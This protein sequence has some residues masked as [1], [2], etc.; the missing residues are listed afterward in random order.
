MQKKVLI[1]GGGVSGLIAA[2][3][4]QRRGVDYTL[5]EQSNQLGGRIAT[6][7]KN[8]YLFDHGFQVL[9][10]AYPEAQAYLDY[11]A[12]DLKSFKPGARIFRQ[13]H[14]STISDPFRDLSALFETLFSPIATLNDK[15]LILKLRNESKKLSI[16]SLFKH[17]QLSTA[18][19]LSEYG[20][21]DSIIEQ[22]FQP[23]FAG[24][25]LE[26]G[27]STSADAF[28]FIYK[29]FT[30]GDAAVPAKGIGAIIRQLEERVNPENILTSTHISNID[31]T[32]LHL[33]NGDVLQGTDVI[34][35]TGAY[36]IGKNLDAKNPDIKNWNGTDCI[37][38]NAPTSL[39]KQPYLVLNAKEN[40]LINHI[41]FISDIAPDY[42]P[43]G[44]RLLS[45]NLSSISSLSNT[46]LEPQILS[47][48]QE[49]F[50]IQGFTWLDR[51][52]IPYSLPLKE[53]IEPKPIK[54]ADNVFSAGDTHY[55][56]SVNFA[57]KSGREAV[58]AVLS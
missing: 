49:L 15:L 16:S 50:G 19:F 34:L 2:I 29:M 30:E 10:T 40:R 31:G 44:K 25:Y 24:I 55:F 51:Y 18:Q 35:A 47:E 3:E 23:F 26:S 32:T 22:F 4:L 6:D 14:F 28:R 43:D 58:E 46:D 36:T 56:G 53:T 21:S 38:V 8:G 48:L 17:K 13:G 7:S 54:L 37:Y 45:V 9:Q 20:F 57:M 39:A 52:T 11:S 33:K 1:A 42:A 41:A 27:L 5:I 12:L